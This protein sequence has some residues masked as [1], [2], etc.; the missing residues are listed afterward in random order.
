MTFL[1]YVQFVS[2]WPPIIEWRRCIITG[3]ICDDLILLDVRQIIAALQLA[4]G[5]M[6]IILAGAL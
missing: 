1:K 5:R 4:P 3:V 6:D 2:I